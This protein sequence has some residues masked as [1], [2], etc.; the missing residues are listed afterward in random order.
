MNVLIKSVLS[1][2]TILTVTGVVG[3]EALNFRISEGSPVVNGDGSVAFVVRAPEAGRVT[4]NGLGDPIAMAKDSAGTWSVTTTPLAPDLYTYSF[5]IDGV[6]TLDPSNIYTARDIAALSSVVIVPGG[7]AD[8]YGVRDVPHGNVSKVW[9]DSPTLG[10]ERRMTVY[11]PAGYDGAGSRRYPVLYLL[12]GMGGDEE[13]WG[14][15]GRATTVLDNLIAEGK[16]EPMIVV[17]PNGNGD[18]P[19]APGETGRGL[20]TPKGEDSRSAPG[21]FENSFK[22]IVDYVDSHYLTRPEKSGRAIAGLS[23]GG[24]HSWRISMA[25]PDMFDYV[26]LFSAAVRWNGSGVSDDDTGLNE[27]LDRQF[28]NAPRLYW[29][30]IGDKD[31]LYDIN[32]DYRRLLDSKGISY[33]YY[34]SGGGHTWTNWRKYLTMFLPRLFQQK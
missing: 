9:Y 30:A 20:Y 21:K 14:E 13:A 7:T 19:A 10:T 28:G 16:A 17:M 22:D 1:I 26:G 25:N 4:V 24:G 3:Q 15:L 11:T 12:H 5:D 34:E 33:E 23:M 8:F 6:R 29:I 2:A 31:F 32:K 18:L 27:A